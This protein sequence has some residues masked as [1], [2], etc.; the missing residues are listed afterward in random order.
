MLTNR[1]K[2]YR[3]ELQA[4]YTDCDDITRYMGR[5]LAP[6]DGDV[7]FEP[8]A[9]KGRLIS[10]V[11]SHQK[12]IRVVANEIDTVD[13]QELSHKFPNAD[14][15]LHQLDILETLIKRKSI[16]AVFGSFNKVIANPPYGAWIAPEKR[17]LLKR[18]IPQ[19]YTKESYGIFLYS[20]L[21]AL[22][23]GGKLVF[24][25]PDTFLW[26]NRHQALRDYVFKHHHVEELA[27]FPSGYFPQISYGYSGMCILS[28]VKGRAGGITKLHTAF[29]NKQALSDLSKSGASSLCKTELRDFSDESQFGNIQG[30]DKTR[31]LISGFA[32]H[33]LGEIADVKTGFYSGNDRRWYRRASETVPRSKDYQDIEPSL[34]AD[35]NEFSLGGINNESAHYIPVIKGGAGVLV[36]PVTWYVNWSVDAV[37][38]YTRKGR[39][40][41]A[42]FQNRTY[43]LKPGIGV[44]MVASKKLTAF[45]I[46]GA[47]FDQGVVGIFPQQEKLRLFL[48]GYLNTQEASEDLKRINPTANNSANYMKRLRVPIPGNIDAI[49]QIS[50]AVAQ[51][52]TNAKTGECSTL[53]RQQLEILYSPLYDT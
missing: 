32:W 43:Y 7:V 39:D 12:K 34:I 50:A 2:R 8:C 20:C 30:S 27:L 5:L 46:E 4:H 6:Q 19:I 3:D 25:I 26:L 36:K 9:G 11:F 23:E 49:E 38:S 48:L 24:I 13:F 45:E 52:L 40:N 14:L 42:R 29:Q 51:L 21:A 15:D 53:L 17:A 47:L 37:Q 22:E 31:A 18:A 41:P 35:S 16:R 33:R 1:P 44:P 10:Q 28:V